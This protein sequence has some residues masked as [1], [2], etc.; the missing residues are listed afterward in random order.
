MN[1][2]EMTDH[3]E[4]MTRE[5]NLPICDYEGCSKTANRAIIIHGKTDTLKKY[6]VAHVPRG[7]ALFDIFSLEPLT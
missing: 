6:C 7:V 3:D 2:N 1:H 4:K 5:N